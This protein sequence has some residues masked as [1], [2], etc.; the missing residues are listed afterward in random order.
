MYED[1]LKKIQE[2]ASKCHSGQFRKGGEIPYIVHP[3]RV[4]VLLKSHVYYDEGDM[5][6]SQAISWLHDVVEDCITQQELIN[7]LQCTVSDDR[8]REAILDGVACLT[9]DK[10]ITPRKT[11]HAAYMESLRAGDRMHRMI[12]LADRIDNLLDGGLNAGFVK[13]V[14][15][16]ESQDILTICEEVD[17]ISAL[18]LYLKIVLKEVSKRYGV[19]N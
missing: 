16:K 18:S 5:Y 8:Y 15:F 7:F 6:T 10:S 2:F 19:V 13:N 4:G 14:Y 1:E 11:R 12:K 17:G 3:A 9:E